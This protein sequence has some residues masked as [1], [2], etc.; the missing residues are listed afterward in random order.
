MKTRTDFAHSNIQTTAYHDPL[1]K[2]SRESPFNPAN[3]S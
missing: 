3:A 1:L 2:Q